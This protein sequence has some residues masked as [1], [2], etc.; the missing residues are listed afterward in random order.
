MNKSPFGLLFLPANTTQIVPMVGLLYERPGLMAALV[1]HT[2]RREEEGTQREHSEEKQ[3]N[4]SERHSDSFE[5]VWRY[6]T[7]F[8]LL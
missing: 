4:I 5:M 8:Y 3:A 1:V 2:F 7:S 6:Y